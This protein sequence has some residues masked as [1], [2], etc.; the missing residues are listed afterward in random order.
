MSNRPSSLT[1]R[2]LAPLVGA[3]LL[4]A[5][6]TGRDRDASS[7]G[8]FGDV[9]TITTTD[10]AVDM[11]LA[12]DTIAV[13]LSDRVVAKARRDMD[14]STARDTSGIGGFLA[15]TVTSAVSGALSTRVTVPVADVKDIRYE[16]G[17]IVMELTRRPKLPLDKFK[18]NVRPLLES[19]PPRDA[20]RFVDA[21]R[22]AKRAE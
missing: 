9:L 7:S 14:S 10:S 11:S 15:R 3:A 2:A 8:S 4:A 6:C 18:M 16:N 12:D 19:F 21:V 13:H 17:A 20:E 1:R 22:R 5:S